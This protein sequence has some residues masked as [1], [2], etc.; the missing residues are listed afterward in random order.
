M[1]PTIQHSRLRQADR[2]ARP[3]DRRGA[4]LLEVVLSVS[5]LLIAIGVCG[6]AVR[7][8]MLSVQRAEE[9]TRSMLLTESILNDLD[10]GVLLPEEEQSGDFSAVGL[11]SWNWELRIVPV[12]QE[13]ELLRVTVSLFQQGSGGGSDDRRTLLT[14]STLRARP[15]TLNLKEDFGLSEEQTKVLTEAIPGGSQML[16]PEN[17]DPR[18]L[19]KLDMDTLI[20]MLP[21]I[22]Q[23]L[24]AQGAPGLEQLGQG[25]EGGGLPQGM[26]PDA[27]QGGGRST[28]QPRT[29]GSPPPSPGSGS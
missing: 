23:A 3:T 17:F 19:A 1:N 7:N 11:P 12:E 18:A 10:T 27:Q 13:P 21:L 25:A 20:Q 8:S 6:S 24:S 5:I 14:T 26:T 28:R 2:R 4:M 16:D 22:M 9:I 29:P 15:R